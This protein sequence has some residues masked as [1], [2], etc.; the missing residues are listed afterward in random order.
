MS[1]MD[2]RTLLMLLSAASIA[3][4]L[5]ATQART[6]KTRW[7]VGWQQGLDAC[8]LL[9][10]VSTPSLQSEAY[11]EECRYWQERLSP[12]AKDALARVR[13][14]IDVQGGLLGPTLALWASATRS[15]SIEATREAFAAPEAMRT[16]L[17]SKEFWGS[18]EEWNAKAAYFPDVAAV[19]AELAAQGF[20][21]YW[22]GKKKPLVEAKVVHLRRELSQIDMIG[23]QQRY[24]GRPLD[25]QIE[26][27]LSA[28]SE[29]HGIRI[30]GQRFLTSFDYPSIIVKRNAAHEIFHP[31]LLSARPETPRILA[32]LSQEP[33]LARIDARADKSDGYR[34]IN[35]LVEEGMTQALEALVSRRLGF[36]RGDLGAY[37]RDQDG[38]IH[39]FAA[40]ALDAMVHSGFAAR[41]GDALSWLDQQTANGNLRGEK[42]VR[43]AAAIIGTE[44]VQKWLA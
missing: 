35:A 23:A 36:G 29:P 5:T 13:K 40:A 22:N 26:I 9:G 30:V 28:F 3:L 31:V 20:A 32:R 39:V 27:Y 19:L 34:T 16:K 7:K 37:W 11:P 10:V 17:S 25:P 42:L 12:T 6:F 44:A 4:P 14:A 38:G 15:D 21:D 43:H 33:V 24:V 1:R 18:A 2:R 41:G 8:L